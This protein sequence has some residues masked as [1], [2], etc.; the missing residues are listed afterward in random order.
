MVWRN[1]ALPAR[2][3]VGLR[4]HDSAFD[5]FVRDR[6]TFLFDLTTTSDLTCLT[7]VEGGVGFGER[8]IAA[9]SE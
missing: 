7:L 4:S 3:G 2:A 8:V 1:S 6:C 5:F 9:Y